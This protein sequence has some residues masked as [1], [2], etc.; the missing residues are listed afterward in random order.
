MAHSLLPALHVMILI[1][2]Q[3]SVCA[4]ATKDNP[5][6]GLS[7]ALHIAAPVG[8]KM[9]GKVPNLLLSAAAAAAANST[10]ARSMVL[11]ENLR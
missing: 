5:L 4:V 2:Y 7:N 8:G 3:V 11:F 9:S 6:E 10:V 1:G